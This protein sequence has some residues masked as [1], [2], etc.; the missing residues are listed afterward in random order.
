[1]IAVEYDVQLVT[2][3]HQK[4]I[5]LDAKQMIYHRVKELQVFCEGQ[6]EMIFDW[7]KVKENVFF[8]QSQEMTSFSQVR[9][10]AS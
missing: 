9:V 4:V 5:A 10:T 8:W 2:A 3:W 1:M 6:K 7:Q